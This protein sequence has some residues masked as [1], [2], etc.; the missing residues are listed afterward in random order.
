MTPQWKQVL[1]HRLAAEKQVNDIFER[2]KRLTQR[3]RCFCQDASEDD[4]NEINREK[5]A[6]C[7]HSFQIQEDI[8]NERSI[9]IVKATSLGRKSLNCHSEE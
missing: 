8:W 4:H 7:M 3:S 6:N 2:G 1:I 5:W 9:S